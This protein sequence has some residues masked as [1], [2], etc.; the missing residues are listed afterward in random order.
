MLGELHRPV[1]IDFFL[2]KRDQKPWLV[3]PPF[4]LGNVK[5]DNWLLQQ[6]LSVQQI[7]SIDISALQ[8]LYHLGAS[9]RRSHFRKHQTMH[10][11]KVYSQWNGSKRIASIM[12]CRFSIIREGNSRRLQ[13]LTKQHRSWLSKKWHYSSR[14][15]VKTHFPET[16]FRLDDR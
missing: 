8:Q 5:W 9:D 10:N 4:L 11:M 6:F 16:R 14:K 2:Y 15:H 7:I 12:D 3:F 13:L 1:G